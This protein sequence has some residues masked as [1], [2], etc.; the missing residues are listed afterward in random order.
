MAGKNLLINSFRSLSA[1]QRQ[2]AWTLMDEDGVILRACKKSGVN[3]NTYY[4]SWRLNP[5]YK[6]YEEFVVELCTNSLEMLAFDALKT[7]LE[8]GDIKAVRTFYE[9]KGK[10]KSHQTKIDNNQIRYEIKFGKNPNRLEP[11]TEGDSSLD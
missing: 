6:K 9:L 11:V 8:K 2:F 5:A 1:K 4:K 7:G 3:P 10:L